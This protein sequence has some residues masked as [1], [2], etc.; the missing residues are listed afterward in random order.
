MTALVNGHPELR[1]AFHGVS[2]F[3]DPT[4]G[5]PFGIELAMPEIH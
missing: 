4:D 5:T 3:A 1:K 2:L